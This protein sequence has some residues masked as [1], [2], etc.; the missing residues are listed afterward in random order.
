MTERGY[1]LARSKSV[2]RRNYR[3]PDTPRF[4]PHLERPSAP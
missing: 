2:S 3:I 4:T 1:K